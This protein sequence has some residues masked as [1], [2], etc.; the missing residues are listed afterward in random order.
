MLRI[1]A[2][3]VLLLL[4]SIAA[5]GLA[6]AGPA[7][8]G[9]CPTCKSV[10]A[11]AT[12]FVEEFEKVQH[13]TLAE[14]LR[15]A[16]TVPEKG[17]TWKLNKTSPSVLELLQQITSQNYRTARLLRQPAGPA[18][19]T[20]RKEAKEQVRASFEAVSRGVAAFPPGTDPGKIQVDMRDVQS[21]GREFMIRHLTANSQ[22][23]GEL[24]VWAQL[25]SERKPAG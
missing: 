1:P 10:P 18:T 17:Y 7:K 23:L 11:V 3:C 19:A 12:T 6:Q 24:R 9:A 14:I 22:L 8:D 13:E 20:S 4:G 2:P 16:E 25:A 21:S 5:A 15:I